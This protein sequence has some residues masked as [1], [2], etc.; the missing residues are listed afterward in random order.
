MRRIKTKTKTFK[1]DDFEKLQTEDVK[2]NT[3][4]NNDSFSGMIETSIKNIKS[5]IDTSVVVGEKIETNDGVTI[6][7]ISKVSVGFITGGGNYKRRNDLTDDK[8][9]I[10]FAGGTGA[11]FSVKP[12]GFAVLK[13]SNLKLLRIEPNELLEK[14]VDNV[15]DII[16]NIKIKL[17]KKEQ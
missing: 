3:K 15:P 17:E 13:N 7:P 10:T 16:K 1:T 5:M 12:V 6:F 11:G 14:I 9:K 8:K 4:S 2:E